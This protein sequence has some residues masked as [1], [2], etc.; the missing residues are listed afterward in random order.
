MRRPGSAMPRREAAR[1]GSRSRTR[2]SRAPTATSMLVGDAADAPRAAPRLSQRWPAAMRAGSGSPRAFGRASTRAARRGVDPLDRR[3]RLPV[4]TDRP[5][6]V[7]IRRQLELLLRERE[8]VDERLLLLGRRRS[9]SPGVRYAIASVS[10]SSSSSDFFVPLEVRPPLRLGLAAVIVEQM[11]QQGRLGR[12]SAGN[13]VARGAR[14]TR[15]RPGFDARSPR[16]VRPRFHGHGHAELALG[17][18]LPLEQPVAQLQR[19]LAV[20]LVVVAR[21]RRGCASPVSQPSLE[22][23]DRLAALGHRALSG[24]GMKNWRTFLSE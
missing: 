11:R 20:L 13:G 19:R 24:A 8:R 23:E 5:P 18:R 15:Q 2:D 9:R 14:C 17:L 4:R 16:R 6:D 10:S 12:P 3:P 22:L 21:S 7:G 1:R